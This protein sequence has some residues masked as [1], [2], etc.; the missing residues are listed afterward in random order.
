MTL[1][2]PPDCRQ[3]AMPCI[4]FCYTTCMPSSAKTFWA[5]LKVGTLPSHIQTRE[6]WHASCT[7]IAAYSIIILYSHYIKDTHA[8][9]TTIRHNM[10]YPSWT[11][12]LQSTQE[13]QTIFIS[14]SRTAAALK[15]EF[16]G[17]KIDQLAGVCVPS[18]G[19]IQPE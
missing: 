4:C 19:R 2:K 6:Q 3:A 15:L 18:G 8:Q 11:E 1:Y 7:D 10:Q 5:N 14:G 13:S 9:S 17:H 12:G 16:N